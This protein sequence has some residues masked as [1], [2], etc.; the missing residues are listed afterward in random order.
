MGCVHHPSAP[1]VAVIS[2][3]RYCAN[4]VAGIRAAATQ[5]DP[6]VTPPA[7]FV[8]YKNS[9]EGWQPIAGTGCAHY[10]AH[11]LNIMVGGP[12]NTCLNGFTYRVPLIL[13]GKTLVTGGLGAVQVNDIWVQADRHHTGLVSKIDPPAPAATGSAS[14]PA[15]PIIWITHASSGQHKLATNRFDQYFHGHGD[16]FR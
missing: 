16:F 11:Q 12:P 14:Q 3:L 6:H 13:T 4:C 8:W 7:C 10:V 1:I 15:N 5:L 9:A 2:G